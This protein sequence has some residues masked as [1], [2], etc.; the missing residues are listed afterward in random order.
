MS[1][2]IDCSGWGQYPISSSL[3][4]SCH[5]GWPLGNRAGERKRRAMCGAK[6]DVAEPHIL[7]VSVAPG[8]RV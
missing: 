7:K 8:L 2:N 1:S 4:S 3:G 5:W 6:V